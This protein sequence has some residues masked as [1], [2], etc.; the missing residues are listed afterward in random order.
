MEPIQAGFR[1][2]PEVT[3]TLQMVHSRP[4]VDGFIGGVLL[5]MMPP[6]PG[7]EDWMELR[8]AFTELLPRKGEENM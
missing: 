6:G 2:C 7:T 1:P 8:V 4:L 3:D 5:N